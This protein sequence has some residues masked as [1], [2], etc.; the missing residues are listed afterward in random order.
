MFSAFNTVD[1]AGDRLDSTINHSENK[2][3][4]GPDTIRDVVG[5]F[6]PIQLPMTRTH[7]LR[8]LGG[9][10][11]AFA[12]FTDIHL[13]INVVLGGWNAYY[14]CEPMSSHRAHD[15]QGQHFF[16]QN[17]AENMRKLSEHNNTYDGK[18]R[19]VGPRWAT[20]SQ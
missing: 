1:Q 15:E 16:K 10:D 4:S 19:K 5:H 8:S 6:H 3:L 20:T 13:W 9:F 11:T 7:I 12:C 14:V 17:T 2:L 18:E